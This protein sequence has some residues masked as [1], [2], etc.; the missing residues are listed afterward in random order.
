MRKL[1]TAVLALCCWAS[2]LAAQ[3]DTAITKVKGTKVRSPA[4]T[5]DTVT[6]WLKPGSDP[7]FP[8]SGMQV[9]PALLSGPTLVYPDLLRQAG[10]QGRVI[11]QAVIDTMG[12]AEPWSVKIIESPNE[13]FNQSA[14]NYV[15]GA[16]FRA[17]RVD[18]RAV[19]VLINVPLDYSIPRKPD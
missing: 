9:R 8:Q 5:A 1:T 4:R 3:S 19:R 6:V 10:V 18:G 17:G 2:V 12:R 13:G 14:R 7:V 15:L 11:V 16:S